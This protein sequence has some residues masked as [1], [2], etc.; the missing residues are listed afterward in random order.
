MH[1]HDL[2]RHRSAIVL[3]SMAGLLALSACSDDGSDS[4]A[5]AVET[6]ESPAATIVE[7]TT[8]IPTTTTTPPIPLTL[9]EDGLG[10]FD[11]GVAPDE[12]IAAATEQFGAPAS[13]TSGAYPNSNG[14]GYFRTDDS[15]ISFIAQSGRSVCWLSGFCVSFGGVD[16]A[17]Q[18][19][20]GWSYTN[21]AAATLS[22]SSGLTIGSRASEH[23]EIALPAYSC[24]DEAG[25][26]EGSTYV[27]EPT[28]D[29]GSL[30]LVLVEVLL[31][32][33]GLPFTLIS[34]NDGSSSDGPPPPADQLVVKQ[35]AAGQN[36]VHVSTSDCLEVLS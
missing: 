35:L 32:S 27:G 13:D 24:H 1:R 36:P 9:R 7:T 6:S 34:S 12:V 26:I 5:S 20:T 10:P 16:G 21:D 14:A 3:V 31:V 28:A 2:A 11:F 22:T 25:T 17:S 29:R 30:T 23:P 19:F 8:T 4:S 15:L 33:E 18:L